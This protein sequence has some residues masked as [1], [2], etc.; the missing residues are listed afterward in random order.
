MI[1]EDELKGAYEALKEVVPQMDYDSVEMIVNDVNI[2]RLPEADAEKF[3]QIGKC[4]K[5]LDWDQMEE[6]LGLR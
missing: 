5:A 2:Y 4:L 6:I 1:P 3:I